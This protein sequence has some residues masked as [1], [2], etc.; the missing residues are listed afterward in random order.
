MDILLTNQFDQERFMRDLKDFRPEGD[1]DDSL[2]SSFGITPSLVY[3][4]NIIDE[5]LTSTNNV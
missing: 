4:F 2:P 3:W 5:Y 1:F